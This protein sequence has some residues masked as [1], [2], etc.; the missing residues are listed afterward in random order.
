MNRLFRT[1]REYF[2][3][4]VTQFNPP[5]IFCPISYRISPNGTPFTESDEL[6]DRPQSSTGDGVASDSINHTKSTA[7]CHSHPWPEWVDLMKILSKKGYLGEGDVEDFQNRGTR[8][9]EAN[10]VR[11]ACL[12][13]S[14]DR[15]DLIRYLMV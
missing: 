3:S 5:R 6:E 12:N 11:T 8:V 9:K 13:F 2:L 10:L 1:N 15:F 14:R 7:Y 4:T